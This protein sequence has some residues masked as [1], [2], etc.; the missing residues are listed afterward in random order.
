M[1]EG[2]VVSYVIECRYFKVCVFWGM[3]VLQRSLAAL[4]VLDVLMPVERLFGKA[5]LTVEVRRPLKFL[6]T[7]GQKLNCDRMLKNP[8]WLLEMFSYICS[9]LCFS[10]LCSVL[11]AA[12]WHTLA[13]SRNAFK[14]QTF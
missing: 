2:R 13:D 14:I 1:L 10:S 9:T 3:L 4:A 8:L 12:R 11:L 6:I 5:A 7:A